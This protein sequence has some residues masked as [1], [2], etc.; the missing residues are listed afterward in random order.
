MC[1]VS[2]AGEIRLHRHMKAAPEPVLKA[3]APYREG[4][5]VAVECLCTWSW[6]ADLWAQAGSAF[7]LGHA[8][9]MRA[10]P[11]GNAKTAQ[12]AA[13]KIAVWRRGG[14]LPHAY[15]YPAQRR[16]TRDLLRRRTHLMRTRAE[17]FVHGQT[18][19]RQ[20]TLPELG[21]QIASQAHREGVAERCTDPAVRNSRAV[22][23]ALSPHDDQRRT[24]LEWSLVKAAT[25]PDANPLSLG[26]TV[27]GIGKMLSRVRRDAI[28][29]LDRCPRGQDCVASGRLVKRA[30]ASAGT[31]LG[32]SGQH[33]GTAHRQWAFSEAAAWC[34]R[35]KP[36]GPKRLAR[37]EHH[38]GQGKALTL[39]AHRLARAVSHR[40][41]H[42]IACALEQVLQR[43]GSRA[44]EPDASL[45]TQGIRLNRAGSPSCS[46]ASGNAEVRRGLV[47]RSLGPLIGPPLW[48]LN[49]RRA[50]RPGNVGGPL[51]LYS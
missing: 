50:S 21:Q 2:R 28:H 3:M 32:T 16:A 24:A 22:D 30:K 29:D 8:R 31:R 12:I 38:H 19:T 51:Y 7:V 48:R 45:D 37:L 44:G 6:L 40:L 41:N 36:A 10:I 33:L 9:S 5:V 25:H 27:P 1:I 14:L 11:G 18:T 13:H 4:L 42:A 47:S 20:D 46:T 39:L 35:Q 23:W 49:S 43:E 17:R 15:I 34:R 26:H